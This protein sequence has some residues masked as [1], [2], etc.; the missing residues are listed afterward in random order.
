[1]LA[2]KKTDVSCIWEGGN[3]AKKNPAINVQA[4]R[5]IRHNLV[6]ATYSIMLPWKATRK[7]PRDTGYAFNP[8]A[9]TTGTMHQFQAS[10]IARA[11]CFQIKTPNIRP[12]PGPSRSPFLEDTEV[13]MKNSLRTSIQRRYGRGARER[14]EV[15]LCRTENSV[16]SSVF[17]RLLARDA[18]MSAPARYVNIKVVESTAF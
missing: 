9:Y 17:V 4:T 8:S 7:T 2:T 11:P 3:P 14:F 13:T 10:D 18:R 16:G 15:P 6:Q 12:R 1:M 5:Y